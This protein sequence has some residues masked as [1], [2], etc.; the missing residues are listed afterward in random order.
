MFDSV[1][2]GLLVVVPMGAGRLVARLYIAFAL[3]RF[4]L[5]CLRGGISGGGVPYKF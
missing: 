3:G 2:G 4:C 1:E 5:N